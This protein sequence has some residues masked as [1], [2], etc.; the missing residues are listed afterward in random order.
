MPIAERIVWP[1]RAAPAIAETSIMAAVGPTFAILGDASAADPASRRSP[2]YKSMTEIAE[3]DS[4][5]AVGHYIY[6]K[7][8]ANIAE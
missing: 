3:S 7:F 8:P 5:G 4:V 2:Y 6:R 1:N